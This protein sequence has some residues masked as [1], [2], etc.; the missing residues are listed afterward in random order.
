MP[1]ALPR[2]SLIAS[3]SHPL[4]SVVIPT[5][6]QPDQLRE[7]LASVRSQTVSDWEAIVVDNSTSDATARVIDELRDPR[8]RLFPIRN[9]GI[10]ARSRNLGIGESSAPLVAFLDSDDRWH[11]TK[12]ARCLEVL[13]TNAAA[14]LVC[15]LERTVIDG[16]PAGVIRYRPYDGDVARRLITRG[17][18]LSTSAVVARR[19]ALCDVGGFDERDDFVTA[20]DYD[21]WIRLAQRGSFVLLPEV[22]GD[23]AVHSAN[24]C[25]NVARHYAAVRSVVARHVSALRASEAR[26]ALARTWFMEGRT[27]Q[28]AGRFSEAWAPFRTALR[29]NPWYAKTIITALFTMARIRW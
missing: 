21:L 24:A 22:L 9:E 20:E 28:T 23:Y 3:P 2:N 10:I 16:H 14:V 12:L 7:A 8:I 18:C 4:V 5:Y 29:M 19:Q 11:P 25:G 27:H 15:H 26:R 6:N 1:H 17:N 13:A